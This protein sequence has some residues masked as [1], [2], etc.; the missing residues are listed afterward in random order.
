MAFA[1]G[2]RSRL[3]YAKETTFGTAPA[4]LTTLP[5]N[6]HTLDLTKTLIES[7]EIRSDREVA[8]ERH[9]NRSVAGSVDAITPKG[10]GTGQILGMPVKPASVEPDLLHV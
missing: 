1:Q 9:G 2:S 7:A 10:A 3:T 5:K 4:S 8:V 6:G